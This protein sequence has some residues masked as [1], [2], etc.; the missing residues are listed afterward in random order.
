MA[1]KPGPEG[2]GQGGWVRRLGSGGLG[3][4]VLSEGQGASVS[5]PGGLG[6]GMMARA[7]PKGAIFCRMQE[8]FVHPSVQP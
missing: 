4:G 3:Q 5:C 1:R 8:I 7:G 6:Q 2:L